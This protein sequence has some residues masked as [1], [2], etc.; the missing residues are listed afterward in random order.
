MSD[1][2]SGFSDNRI[3]KSLVQKEMIINTKPRGG[4]SLGRLDENGI[5]IVGGKPADPADM[6]ASMDSF[7]KLYRME[8][9]VGNQLKLHEQLDLGAFGRASAPR[10]TMLPTADSPKLNQGLKGMP[11]VQAAAP[12]SK[13]MLDLPVDHALNGR[14]QTVGHIVQM[15]DVLIAKGD[16]RWKEID[17]PGYKE[18]AGWFLHRLSE[19][20][21]KC[22]SLPPNLLPTDELLEKF[23]DARQ[24]WEFWF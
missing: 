11:D 5:I 16:E 4:V 19:F 12:Q 3:T 2:L 7:G 20:R 21:N 18:Y 15:L 13:E 1:G 22:Q 24:G 10:Q 23:K 14:P 8:N 17:H 6:A 9:T